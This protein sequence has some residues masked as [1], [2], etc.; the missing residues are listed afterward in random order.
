MQ[1][2]LVLVEKNTVP[3]GTARK[4]KGINQKELEIRNQDSQFNLVPNPEFLKEGA[5]VDDFIKETAQLL[6]QIFRLSLNK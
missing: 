5:A 6:Q 2:R 4:E 1:K 3:I